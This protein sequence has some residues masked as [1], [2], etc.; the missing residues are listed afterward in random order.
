MSIPLASFPNSSRHK[1]SSNDIF[2]DPDERFEVFQVKAAE[3][4]H[5]LVADGDDDDD[6]VLPKPLLDGCDLPAWRQHHLVGDISS[7]LLG[8]L[9]IGAG[10]TLFRRDSQWP[11][12]DKKVESPWTLLREK[13]FIPPSRDISRVDIDNVSQQYNDD[14]MT[15]FALE[16]ERRNVPV[17]I[18]GCTREWKAMPT[19][20]S[21]DFPNTSSLLSGG[22]QGGWTY[23][24][25]VNVVE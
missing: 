25:H 19:Y 9:H 17:L 6:K 22:G 13:L 2:L 18:Q 12:I 1:T 16:W 3:R 10:S 8:R 4:P 5:L 23:V 21:D 15:K 20:T 11:C 14:G 24:I 7:E